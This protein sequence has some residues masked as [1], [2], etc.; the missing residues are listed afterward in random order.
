[1][2]RRRWARAAEAELLTPAQFLALPAQ[3]D[4]TIVRVLFDE[5]SGVVW[6]F[7]F[8]AA[9]TSIYKWECIGATPARL[10]IA[11]AQPTITG[12]SVYADLAT[13]G[14][15]IV[16]ALA[17][18]YEIRFFVMVQ[19]NVAGAS[20]IVAPK[21]AAATPADNDGAQFSA[22]GNTGFSNDSIGRDL[23][24]TVTPAGSTVKL[25]YSAATAGQHTIY[26]REVLAVPIR[27]LGP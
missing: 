9:A 6:T 11:T 2:P 23:I 21:I 26:R 16:L 1:M 19:T 14:P 18:D 13:P 24:R 3:P 15:S 5:S 8:R 12:G 17:G 22:G 4:G 10:E 20:L 7:R 25:Q 27:V